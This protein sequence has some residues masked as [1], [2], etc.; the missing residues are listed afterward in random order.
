[1]LTAAAAAER[2]ECTYDRL[3]V[4]SDPVEAKISYLETALDCAK[5]NWP[6]LPYHTL[7]VQGGSSQ[8][9]ISGGFKAA[10]T[11]RTIIMEWWTKWPDALIGVPTGPAS[12]FW[13]LTVD[14]DEKEH[15]DGLKT[16]TA[17]QSVP[18]LPTGPLDGWSRS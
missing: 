11:D 8:P 3:V 16:L 15:L 10:S 5:R 17:L 2:Q 9:L 6:V 1:M 4:I 7:P 18:K 14:V 13:V 12:S